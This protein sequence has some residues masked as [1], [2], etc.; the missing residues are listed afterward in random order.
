MNQKPDPISKKAWLI[1]WALLFIILYLFF[2]HFLENKTQKQQLPRK[3]DYHL[4]DNRQQNTTRVTS[5]VFQ[6]ENFI[7]PLL[8]VCAY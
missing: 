2:D 5:N 3:H 4:I 1:L 7:S 8:C 6:G